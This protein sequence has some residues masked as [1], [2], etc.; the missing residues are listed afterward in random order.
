MCAAKRRLSPL[1]V[2]DRPRKNNKERLLVVCQTHVL[3]TLPNATIPGEADLIGGL[4]SKTA[5]Y[6]NLASAIA[7]GHVSPD[8]EGPIF[9]YSYIFCC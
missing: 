4:G 6:W 3:H 2:E 7:L 9:V 1:D 5:N 8:S